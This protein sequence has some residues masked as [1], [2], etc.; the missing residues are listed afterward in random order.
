MPLPQKTRPP[1]SHPLR[2]I[3]S[4]FNS[5][6]LAI[7]AFMCCVAATSAVRAEQPASPVDR[8]HKL[9]LLSDDFGLADGPAWD[10]VS[11]LYVPDVKQSLI[12]RFRPTENEWTVV[13]KGDDRYSAS[14]FS[15]G[16]LF[17]CNNSAARIEAFARNNMAAGPKFVAVLDENEKNRK[18]PND[19]VV[20]Q[21]G[22][23]YLTLTGQNQV[24]YISR[25]GGSTV[26]TDAAVTPN[27][28]TISPDNR[29]LYV[30]AYRPKKIIAFPIMKPGQLGTASEF[31]VMDDGDARGADG[32]SI[33]RA[34][35]VYC[36]G[37]A[38]VWVWA[39]DGSLLDQ[40]VCPTR[41]INCTF[42][43]S[44][45]RTLYITGFGGVYRQRMRISGVASQ[46]PSA[47]TLSGG[48]NVPSTAVPRNVRQYL[49]VV[50]AQYGHRKLLT[51]LFV[52][53]TEKTNVPAIVVVH[54]GGWLN[55]DRTKFRALAIDL[56][57]RGFVT[58][59]IE[60]RLGGEAHF[61]AAIHDCNAAVRFLRAHASEYNVDPEQISAVGGS[62]GGHLVGL[63]A[64]GWDDPGLQGDGGNTDQSSRLH[65]AFVMAGP[66]QTATGNVANKSGTGQTSNATQWLGKS[67]D[68]APKLYKLAD[69]HAHISK[70]TCPIFFMTGEHDN[71]ARNEL[72]RAKLNQLGILTS[73]MTY[74]DGKHGCWNR[75]P[76][77]SRMADEIAHQLATHGEGN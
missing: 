75:H 29:T 67:I 71:P 19:L 76:W 27:G 53:R 39:P 37:A 28:I 65:L 60:Y 26:V 7:P 69:A 49:N 8:S 5:W 15:H 12:K 44:N 18:R 30:A 57:R 10:G 68:E 73:L 36:A 23:V 42:G 51:D 59:A 6:L 45:M 70:S 21:N 77:F 50:Y 32:M 17:V 33:D 52:P 64:S 58:A 22:G 25:E 35:N 41:P 1:V 72:S 34:G 43:D 62:A 74:K 4:A 56:A 14:I 46:P 54:G 61:P 3:T 16:R 47:A 40:I 66:M 55:G 11:S 20:D 2:W 31:A 38:D 24:V 13:H 9:E 48:R 63:M